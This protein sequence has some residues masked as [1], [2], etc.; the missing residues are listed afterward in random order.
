[1]ILTLE[2]IKTALINNEMSYDEAA[3]LIYDSKK[4]PWQTKE[5]QDK[6]K[7]LIKDTCERWC[8][9]SN[10][11]NVDKSINGISH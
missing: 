9:S 1:M 2:Q 10:V 5:W 6:R 8:R 4:K 7:Q 11:L 3:K